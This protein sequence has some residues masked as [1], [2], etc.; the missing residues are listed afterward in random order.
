MAPGCGWSER[1]L[2][3]FQKDGT[4]VGVC[5]FWRSLNLAVSV[6]DPE[7]HRPCLFWGPEVPWRRRW[8]TW[9]WRSWSRDLL[10]W[11]ESSWCEFCHSGFFRFAY[12]FPHAFAFFFNILCRV[13]N[14]FFDVLFKEQCF[15][16]NFTL[17]LSQSAGR[18][19]RC[20]GRVCFWNVS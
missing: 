9:R 18:R 16:V 8:G 10:L 11:R 2:H 6:P 17:P 15:V 14:I 7:L 19:C 12:G 13:L 3:I 5:S 1:M 4:K 20:R